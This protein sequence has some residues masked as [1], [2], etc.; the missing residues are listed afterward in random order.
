MALHYII[1][2]ASICVNST[3]LK[4]IHFAWLSS[5]TAVQAI[6]NDHDASKTPAVGPI[7]STAELVPNHKISGATFVMT[8]N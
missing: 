7:P 4:V 3:R 1:S 5:H 2:N 6:A 8:I